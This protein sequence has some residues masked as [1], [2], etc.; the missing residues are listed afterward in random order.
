MGDHPPGPT[1]AARAARARDV[2]RRHQ[3]DFHRRFLG[4]TFEV[5]WEGSEPAPS[6]RRWS[7]L[8]PNYIRTVFETDNPVDLANR[9]TTTELLS[10]V[11]GGVL[12]EPVAW[13]SP[14]LGPGTP[15]TR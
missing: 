4:R 7:G 15:D 5:L 10:V 2:A 12:G 1:A 8:T 11:P 13:R 6:G 3:D 14:T 9:V